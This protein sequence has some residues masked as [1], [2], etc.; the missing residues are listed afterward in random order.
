MRAFFKFILAVLFI[1]FIMTISFREKKT[2][3]KGTVEEEYGVEVVKNPKKP[4]HDDAVFSLKEDLAIGEKERKVKN[5][6]YLLTDMDADSNGNIYVLDSEDT[7]IK[8][9]DQKGRFLRVFS[10][11]GEGPGQLSN[12]VDIYIDDKNLIYVCD[13]GNKRISIFNDKGDFVKHINFHDY[14]AGKMVGINPLGGIVLRVDKTSLESTMD[15]ITRANFI[16]MYSDRFDFKRNLY[17]ISVPIMQHFRKGEK[18][19]TLTIPYQKELCWTLDS[20]GNVYIGESQ[21]YEIQVFSP[22]GKKIRRIEKEYEPSKVSK[23][24]IEDYVKDQFLF[25]KKERIFWSTTIKQQLRVPENKP[26][27]EKFFFAEDRLFVL[28]SENGSKGR[29]FFDIFDD[30]GRYSWKMRLKIR[31][32]T[33]KNNKIYAVEKNEAGYHVIK[34]YKVFW[35][36]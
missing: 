31:P 21:T 26:V 5:M 36:L 29:F 2:A 22:S 16:N 24:D 6:F 1:V 14:S 18:G 27:F 9:Y 12:P 28:R 20:S 3:W 10:R 13:S 17:S 34:R 33:W 25:D 4:T 19:I 11:K 30:E 7:N 23:P 32:W 35:R 15:F 8:V